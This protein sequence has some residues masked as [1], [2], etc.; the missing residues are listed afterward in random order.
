MGSD[1]ALTSHLG[2]RTPDSSPLHLHFHHSRSKSDIIVV[3]RHTTPPGLPRRLPRSHLSKLHMAIHPDYPGLV[4][5]VVVNGRALDEHRDDE[6]PDPNTTSVYIEAKAGEYFAVRYTL[7]STQFT[8]YSIKASVRLDG[9]HVRANVYDRNIYSA[10]ITQL[11]GTSSAYVGGRN[12]GQRF[13]F[14]ALTTCKSFP[15]I[16]RLRLIDIGID[17]TT[18]AV[19]HSL[20]KQLASAG[21]ISV[22]L[23]MVKNIRAKQMVPDNIPQLQ[24]PSKVPEKALKGS[25]VSHKTTYG[26][27]HTSLATVHSLCVQTRSTDASQ[28]YRMGRCRTCSLLWPWRDQTLRCLQLPVSL[29][30]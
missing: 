19:D 13:R 21:S 7:P 6:S 4:A 29:V 18:G 14:T 11:F 23:Y 5:D 9:T 16:L 1:D 10:G 28:I 8:T 20:K 17:E 3:I 2:S 22:S 12:M 24:G 30:R 27:H 26:L 15:T 25:S